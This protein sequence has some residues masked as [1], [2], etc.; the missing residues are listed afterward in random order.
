M[1]DIPSSS[2]ESA[3]LPSGEIFM[4]SLVLLFKSKAKELV[5]EE[6]AYGTAWLVRIVIL[7]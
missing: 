2:M 6:T 7:M 4:V 3:I 5:A 1:G